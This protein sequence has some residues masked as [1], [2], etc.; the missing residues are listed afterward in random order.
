MTSR[1]A[2]EEVKGVDDFGEEDD[3]MF[4]PELSQFADGS[5][6]PLVRDRGA[7][8]GSW[9]LDDVDARAVRPAVPHQPLQRQRLQPERVRRHLRADD[10]EQAAH[11]HI[12]RRAL[13]H[14]LER[15][16]LLVR[17]SAEEAARRG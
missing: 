8:A 15:R 7:R 4:G 17:V 9:V 10:R 1:T 16:G 14:R 6:E 3:L 11:L 13:L 2:D 5:A 12:G